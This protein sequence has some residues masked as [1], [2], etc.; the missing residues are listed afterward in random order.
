MYFALKCN[1]AA[2]DRAIDLIFQRRA[3]KVAATSWF[4]RCN[5]PAAQV[6]ETIDPTSWHHAYIGSA[7]APFRIIVG[8][9]KITCS[10][11]QTSSLAC[12]HS[13]PVGYSSENMTE[14]AL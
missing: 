11:V 5:K 7:V 10:W 2:S 4:S 8:K 3:M 14:A 9:R 12:D 1:L 6:L 13:L